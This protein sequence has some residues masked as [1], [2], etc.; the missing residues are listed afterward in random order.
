MTRRVDHAVI[1]VRD[2]EA[3]ATSYRRLGFEVIAGGRHEAHGTANM[4]I[5]LADGAYLELFAFVDKQKPSPTHQMWPIAEAGG[6]LAV[7]WLSGGDVDAD[8]HRMGELGAEYTEP[9]EMSRLRVDGY[10]LDF[11]LA[12]SIG[13]NWN[14]LPFLIEDVTA[15]RDRVPAPVAHPNGIVGLRSIMI[16]VP[17]DSP[18]PDVYARFLENHG[19]VDHDEALGA[20]V[21]RFRLGGSAIDLITPDGQNGALARMIAEHGAGPFGLVLDGASSKKQMFDLNDTLGVRI[22]VR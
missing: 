9:F 3:A 21:R 16:A 14:N 15:R 5:G 4:L 7:F 8:V 20:H 11:R 6:G 22:E 18:I 2:L 12:T 1:V 10:K 17:D 13:D 19:E